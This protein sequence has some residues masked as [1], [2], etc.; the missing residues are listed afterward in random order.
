VGALRI[1]PRIE[2]AD[3]GGKTTDDI[4][5]MQRLFQAGLNESTR[6]AERE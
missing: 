4:V 6:H 5:L 1:H 3:I 2:N